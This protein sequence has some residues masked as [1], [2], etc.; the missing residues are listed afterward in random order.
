MSIDYFNQMNYDMLI[1]QINHK[2]ISI[3]TEKILKLKY[4]I[5]VADEKWYYV[6]LF[7]QTKCYI[8]INILFC[9]LYFYMNDLAYTSQQ[10]IFRNTALTEPK[11]A[12]Q[13]MINKLIHDNKKNSTTSN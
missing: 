1:N 13:S 11:A 5:I 8:L 2:H 6:V 4:V 9:L 3:L 12:S 7:F 10:Y